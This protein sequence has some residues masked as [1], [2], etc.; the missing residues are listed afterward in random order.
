MRSGEGSQGEA[1]VAV[2]CS[3]E[4]GCTEVTLR[5]GILHALEYSTPPPCDRS[6]LARKSRLGIKH[7]HCYDVRSVRKDDVEGKQAYKSSTLATTDG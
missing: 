3:G 1:K 7:V 6:L 2:R 4:Q 5:V